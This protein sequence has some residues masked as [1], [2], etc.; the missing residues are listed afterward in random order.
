M[1]DLQRAIQVLELHKILLGN[2]TELVFQ[3]LSKL[4]FI[5]FAKTLS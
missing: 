5:L 2:V 1:I 4:F 3:K